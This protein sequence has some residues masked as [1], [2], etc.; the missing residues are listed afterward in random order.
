ETRYATGR[1]RTIDLPA[2]GL[3]GSVQRHQAF[4][5]L[6]I[7]QRDDSYC[8]YTGD[9]ADGLLHAYQ[10]NHLTGDLTESGETVS[11]RDEAVGIH[12]T[13][14]TGNIPIAAQNFSGPLWLLPIAQHARGPTHKQKPLAA[15]R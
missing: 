1:H 8:F 13:D 9:L 12:R 2:I 6:G 11:E 14:V 15:G 4:A 5:F 7:G 10:R 3:R